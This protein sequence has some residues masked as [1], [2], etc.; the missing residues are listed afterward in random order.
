SLPESVKCPDI[1]NESVTG[2]RKL[3]QDPTI[4]AAA[5]CGIEYGLNENAIQC[6]KFIDVLTHDDYRPT[7]DDIIRCCAQTPGI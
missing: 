5:N 7:A 2:L 1:S 4:K 3:W 6:L